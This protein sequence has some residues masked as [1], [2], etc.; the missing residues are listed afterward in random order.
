[1]PLKSFISVD[2][3]LRAPTGDALA[4]PARNTVK[5]GNFL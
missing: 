2:I 1:M 3:V 4:M 5:A